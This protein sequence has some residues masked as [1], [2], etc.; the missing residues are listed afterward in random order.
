MTR[1][2]VI[3]F[4]YDFILDRDTYELTTAPCLTN[5]E[6]HILL[7]MIDY[8]GWAT[9]WVSPSGQAIDQDVIE[10]YADSI[11]KKLVWGGCE[12]MVDC[13]E[14]WTCLGVETPP[15]DLLE[16]LREQLENNP[17]IINI[18]INPGGGGAI[19][20]ASD[21]IMVSGCDLD[22]LYAFIVQLVQFCNLAVVNAYE[23]FE[24]LTNWVETSVIV[25][26]EIPLLTWV[27][28]YIQ[29]MQETIIDNYLAEY[30]TVLE[31][32][33]IC[34]LFCLAQTNEQCGLTWF[35]LYEYFLE[36]FGA[37]LEQVDIFDLLEFIC[38]GG[39]SGTE[40]CDL[41]LA[42]FCGVMNQSGEWFGITLEG[43]KRFW[44][45]WLNDSNS[46]WEMLCAECEWSVHYD[47]ADL[48]SY[49][50]DLPIGEWHENE[51]YWATV[52]VT[53]Q[54]C[55]CVIERTFEPAIAKVTSVWADGP[56]IDYSNTHSGA[57]VYLTITHAGGTYTDTYVGNPDG[58]TVEFDMPTPLLNVT[59]IKLEVREDSVGD[60]GYG[61]IQG[62]V[63][64]GRD[65]PKA[66]EPED[67]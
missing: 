7:A 41:S 63:I 10:A 51:D 24:A 40:F 66:P 53:G 25:L 44:N 33:Y 57:G 14:V 29:Y 58:Q 5:G 15:D 20:P 3:Q 39:W 59:Y 42:V 16:W 30:D 67:C 11:A 48:C 52:N 37:G 65:S 61:Y 12:G 17:E 64:V 36:R 50:W 56:K 26:D 8:I 38:G 60:G 9:R 19:A 45:A 6:R 55:K 34:D 27:I 46:D 13:A 21:E 47:F 1:G 43:I 49:Q 32:Q 62:V 22:Q 4:D 18:I 23:R 2:K 31:T 35:Q 54:Y 28:E